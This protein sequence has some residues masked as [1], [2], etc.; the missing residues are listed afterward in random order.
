MSAA[1][2]PVLLMAREL[3]I[4]GSERQMTETAMR[5]DPDTFI[6][7]VGC[8]RPA[9]LRGDELRHSGVAIAEF[10]VYS[11]RSPAAI[12]EA[13][14]LVRYI[15][16]HRIQIVHTWDY[17]LNVY[18]IPIARAMTNALALSSQRSHRELIPPGFRHFVK[19]SDRMSHGVVANCEYVRHHLLEQRIPEEKIRVCYN[20]IDLDRFQRRSVPAH[21][22]TIGVVC[23]LRPE[24][25]L[26]TLVR[27]FAVI[28]DLAPESKLVI[29]G[30][31][32]QLPGLERLANELGIVARCHFEPATAAIP[33][34]LSTMDIFVLPSRSEAFSNS[35]MEAMACGCCAIASDVGG[36]PE[37]IRHNETG[38][39]FPVADSD[40]LAAMLRTVIA[41][42]ATRSR[43]ANAGERLI[44]TNFSA[45]AA[46]ARMGEI[47]LHL[48]EKVRPSVQ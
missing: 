38:L 15:R 39:L 47:Y 33:G 9:G 29:V 4:G 22:L 45:G 2:I 17:P 18:A 24:K 5:L 31:G 46:A 36:N 27:A 14:H 35:L 6:P 23:G 3:H 28:R 34:W 11:Y 26:P 19:L 25:D 48:L 21:P 12:R 32:D 41:E 16:E 8:F 13:A 40:A 7:H 30:S 43:L 44:R 10:P 1:K 20:G 37:L 42:P